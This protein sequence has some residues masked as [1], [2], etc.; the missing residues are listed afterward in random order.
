M[1]GFFWEIILLIFS[2]LCTGQGRR[3]CENDGE[4]DGSEDNAGDDE[5]GEDDGG[6]DDGSE[7]DVYGL[8]N[9]NTNQTKKKVINL[10][11]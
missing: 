5:S 10:I 4:E 7:E 9:N 11:L 3:R 1:Y 6:E 8:L 2:S